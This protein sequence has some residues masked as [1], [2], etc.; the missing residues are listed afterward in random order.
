MKILGILGQVGG[1]LLPGW[2]S[3]S[4]N[5]EKS[6]KT[7]ARTYVHFNVFWHIETRHQ[8]FV[9]LLIIIIKFIDSTFQNYY[10]YIPKQEKILFE[11]IGRTP[12]KLTKAYNRGCPF[13]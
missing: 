5:P 4:V 2:E 13:S 6:W 12:K 9:S 11:S 7:S 8:I 3:G 1:L 10:T